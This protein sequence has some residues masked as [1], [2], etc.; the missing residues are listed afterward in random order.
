MDTSAAGPTLGVEEEFLVVDPVSGLPVPLGA[1]VAR[2]ARERFGAD[3]DVEMSAAQVEART[4][5]CHDLGEVRRQLSGLR[6]VAAGSARRVGGVL[7]AVGVPP[8][9]GPETPTTDGVRYRQLGEDFRLLAA[10]QSISGCHVHVGVP[11]PETAVQVCNH[12][13]PWLPVL[14]ALT[15]NSPIA[16][17]RDTGYAS[18]RSV[19]WSRWPSAGPPP[20]FESA[21]DYERT[22]A[23]LMESGAGRDTRMVYWDVRPSAHLPTAE[24]RVADVAATVDEAVL[25]A[26]LV[27]ALVATALG[28]LRRGL[29]ASRVPTEWL[30]VAS[31][32][33]A[34][35]GVGGC[36]LDV[37]SG[38]LVPMRLLVDRLVEVAR[39]ALCANGDLAFVEH[40]LSVVDSRG[41][42]ADRQRRVFARGG[43]VVHHVAAETLAGCER[44]SQDV[45][46]AA[47]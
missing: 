30:R 20:Y 44:W 24:V 14:G 28:D 17:G 36:G 15:A 39:D 18:W 38:R 47:G 37:F 43:G 19:V 27:R 31:W 45:A 9:G 8:V 12:V 32:R 7:L 33:A 25:L 26:G 21:A 11:D 13:R 10:E 40:S 41:T 23:M 35:D 42:G 4:T 1:E 3:L 22:C 46:Q 5:V 29:R 34:R 16:C 6:A 2:Y